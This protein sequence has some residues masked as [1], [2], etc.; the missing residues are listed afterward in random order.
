M[1]GG[2]DST[3]TVTLPNGLIMKWGK[4]TRTG[5]TTTV[6]FA[7]AFTACFQVIAQTANGSGG[8]INTAVTSVTAANFQFYTASSADSPVRWFAIGR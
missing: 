6:T 1:S 3:G 8:S 5:A 7:A 4:S 2:N